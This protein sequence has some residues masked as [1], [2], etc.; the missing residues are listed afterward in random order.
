MPARSCQWCRSLRAR[1]RVLSLQQPGVRASARRCAR[2]QACASHAAS[3]AKRAI[4]R[5]CKQPTQQPSKR[6]SSQ[7]DAR[8]ACTRAGLPL[9]LRALLAALWGRATPSSSILLKTALSSSSSSGFS[10]RTATHVRPHACLRSQAQQPRT[11]FL[12][13]ARHTRPCRRPCAR[14][15]KAL[16]A[17]VGG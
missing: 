2:M 7:A 16:L 4:Q 10:L 8:R 3:R 1:G 14:C 17:C 13:A 9:R 12:C 15:I 5:K 11:T 6:G